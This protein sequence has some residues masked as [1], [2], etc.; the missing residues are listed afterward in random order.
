MYL[1]KTIAAK[2]IKSDTVVQMFNQFTDAEIDRADRL[3]VWGSSFN[4]QSD[5][6]DFRLMKDAQVIA[7]FIL[8]G[9]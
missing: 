2:D 4:E 3:E 9:Y 7:N 6:N 1:I 8:N 5:K